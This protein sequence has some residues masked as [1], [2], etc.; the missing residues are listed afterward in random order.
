MSAFVL[1]VPG[2]VSEWIDV[3]AA[4]RKSGANAKDESSAKLYEGL[5]ARCDGLRAK[6][7]VVSY[8]QVCSWHAARQG[9]ETKDWASLEK[10]A[11][12]DK[13]VLRDGLEALDG[14]ANPP[15]DREVLLEALVVSGVGWFLAR[16]VEQYNDLT[17]EA[18]AA[19]FTSAQVG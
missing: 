13:L 19:F 8:R 14:V 2:T 18:R 16:M 17:P 6:L 12:A 5:A 7:R 3:G 1:S 9:L 15:A 11:E 10:Y 4:A